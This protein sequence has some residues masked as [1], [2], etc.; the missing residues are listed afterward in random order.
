MAFKFTNWKPHARNA[1]LT[2]MSASK[3]K[4]RWFQFSLR[5][6]LIFVTLCAIP[7]SWLAVKLQQAKRQRE[8][9]AE[10]VK[11][12][13]AVYYDW[14]CD[15]DGHRSI[16]FPWRPTPTWWQNLLGDDLFQS[17]TR[18]NLP[19]GQV[20]DADLEHLKYLSQLEVLLIDNTQVTD[21]GLENLKGLK[22]LNRLY[23]SE[24]K[25]T[26]EGIKRLQQALPN[27]RIYRLPSER[28]KWESDE[29][30]VY[31]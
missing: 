12:N 7:C 22:H 24:T 31:Y 17:V 13:G 10:I 2:G 14:E 5:S 19:S 1:I 26:D 21:A 3:P 27:C 25:V 4:L 20:T 29:L 15:K 16:A 9:V 6:L 28:R 30:M 18:V 23:L 11:A 8:A